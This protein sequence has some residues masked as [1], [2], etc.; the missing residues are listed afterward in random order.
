M[1]I[2]SKAGAKLPPS[3]KKPM[4]NGTIMEAEPPIK[5]N[6]PPVNP[7]K[8]FGAKVETNTQAIEAMPLSKKARHIKKT[9]AT[10]LSA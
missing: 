3:A 1:P 7:G 2:G 5:L 4:A 9:I 10:L 6:T 8:F